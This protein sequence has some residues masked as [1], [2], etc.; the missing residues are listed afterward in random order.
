MPLGLARQRQV[1][2]ADPCTRGVSLTQFD[3]EWHSFIKESGH[4][5]GEKRPLKPKPRILGARRV[6]TCCLNPSRHIAGRCRS[7]Q[8]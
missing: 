4:A 6:C 5:Y 8:S 2:V 7:L 1:C 3:N